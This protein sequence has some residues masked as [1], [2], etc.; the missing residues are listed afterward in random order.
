ME[1]LIATLI[2]EKPK[3]RKDP[4]APSPFYSCTIAL[5]KMKAPESIEPLISILED[6][7]KHFDNSDD[8]VY[9]IV[10]TLVAISG[11]K[12][13]DRDPV[14]WR[15]WWNRN[16]GRLLGMNPS[17]PATPEKTRPP[18]APRRKKSAVIGGITLQYSCACRFVS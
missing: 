4:N 16:K 18:L 12:G 11:E 17:T 3:L 13:P 8:I 2:E 7:V 10:D 6:S 15:L 5:G 14:K 1:S 9:P